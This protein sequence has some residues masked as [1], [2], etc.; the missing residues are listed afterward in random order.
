VSKAA[1]KTGVEPAILVAIEQFYPA[2]ERVLT[3]PLQY[4]FL[5]RGTKILVYLLRPRFML[6]WMTKAAVNSAPG[7][8]G[9]LLCRKR[10]IDEKLEEN[11]GIFTQII[12]LGAGLDTRLYRLSGIENIRAWEL[13][14]PENIAVKRL[15]VQKALGKPSENVKLVP[16]DF[17]TQNLDEIL[18]AAGYSTEQPAFFIWE[19]VTQ[20]LSE[21]GIRATFDFLAKAKSGSL[22][23]FTYARKKFLEGEDILNWPAGYKRFVKTGVWL[24]GMEP[25]NWPGFLAEYGWKAIEDTDYPTMAEKYIKPTG[26]VLNA[27]TQ[28]ERMIFATKI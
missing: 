8:W 6:N 20:Y 9:G 25:D 27:D 13:D 21:A 23:T 24:F 3:D 5:P 28:V 11:V 7:L 26:R 1:A 22:I 15:A 17:D 18:Q 16:I 12:N 10:Y 19:A 2:Y 4:R 14:Q